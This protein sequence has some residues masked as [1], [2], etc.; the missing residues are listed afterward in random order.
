[1]RKILFTLFTVFLFS[2]LVAQEKTKIEWLSIQEAMALHKEN[3]KK[4]MIDVY[5]DWCGWCKR[6]DAT[7]FQDEK[8]AKYISE[9][10]YAVKLNA[11]M[12]DTIMV[13]DQIF[14]NEKPNERRN[15]HQ[16]AITFLGAK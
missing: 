8:I 9:N 2:Q 6:M 3:P 14:V 13:G 10:F 16:L 1:M 12:K 7:T 4:I 11:E 15:P 5:T